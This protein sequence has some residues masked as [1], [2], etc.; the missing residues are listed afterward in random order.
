MADYSS[1][2]LVSM[3]STVWGSARDQS[4]LFA[5]LRI[6]GTATNSV[7][8]TVLSWVCAS[9]LLRCGQ[10]KEY[11]LLPIGLGCV[12]GWWTG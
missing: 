1:K 5:T 9:R 12:G 7:T 4:S 2:G 6:S 10:E 8:T 11:A 3:G